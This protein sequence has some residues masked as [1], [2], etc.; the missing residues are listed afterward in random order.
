MTD[1]RR[2]A[3]RGILWAS[4]SRYSGK[5]LVFISTLVLARLLVQ[6]DFGVAG[7]ALVVIALLETLS[8]LGIGP[9]LIYHED[10]PAARNT[11]FVIGLSA[12]VL[13]LLLSWVGAPLIAEFFRD[14]RATA[15]TRVL[16]LSLPLSAL[17]NVHFALLEKQLQFG[18]KFIPDL[19]NS[20]VKGLSAIVF[21]LSDFGAWSLIYGQL[22]GTL[23][24]VVA[25]WF[26]MPWRPRL[27]FDRRIAAG[28]LDYGS[29]ILAVGVLGFAVANLGNI[30]VGRFLGAAALGVYVLALRIPEVLIK[31]SALVVNKVLFPVFTRVRGDLPAMGRG[32][33]ALMRY[34]ALVIAP[35]GMGLAAVAEPFVLG[36][37]SAKWAEL[38]PVIRIAAVYT[39]VLALAFNAGTVFKSIGRPGI[40]IHLSL[41]RLAILGP[42]LAWAVLG[43]ASL[44]AVAWVHLAAIVIHLLLSLVLVARLLS[45]SV[46]ALFGSLVPATASAVIMYGVVA[47]TT[48][49]LE[50]RA[51]LIVL[52]A[53]VMVGALC[54]LGLVWIWQRDHLRIGYATVRDS[55]ARRPGKGR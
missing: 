17:G 2:S 27:Q 55:L 54:Y 29:K 53:G 35:L 21:A 19:S 41:L 13:L 12:A 23:A 40:I 22:L 1:L 39:L 15:V 34:L 48:E 3:T 52:A 10:H 50:G 20:I 38:I 26:V 44:V 28:L 18:R 33:I 51:P 6:E 37:L 47:M 11:A 31:E 45:L 25:V 16:A 7:Y 9:A 43:P 30:F 4:A 42:A 5:A 8:G 49:S 14:P 46:G 36:L 24:S 32:Y